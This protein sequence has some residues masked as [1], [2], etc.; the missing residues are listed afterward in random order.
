MV[1]AG[2][3]YEWGEN[4][5]LM[6]VEGEFDGRPISKMNLKDV[7][8]SATNLFLTTGKLLQP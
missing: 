8:C 1:E 5:G 7:A 6:E 4:P 2:K 3:L